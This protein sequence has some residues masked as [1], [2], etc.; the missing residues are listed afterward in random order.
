MSTAESGTATPA[1]AGEEAEPRERPA[2]ALGTRKRFVSFLQN[3]TLTIRGSN[4]AAWHLPEGAET[5]VHTQTRTQ[6]LA[7]P[8]LII[9]QT[10][11]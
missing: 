1:P 7:A 5:H 9:P 11:K 2:T 6:M 4:G 8:L 3:R 10:Q